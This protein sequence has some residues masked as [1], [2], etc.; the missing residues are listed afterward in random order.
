MRATLRA[1]CVHPMLCLMALL[2]VPAQA[3]DQPPVAA[4]A[5]DV[6]AV[7]DQ[8]R[9]ASEVF[10]ASFLTAVPE[11]QLRAL[12]ADMKGQFGQLLRVESVR[13]GTVPGSAEVAFR[14]ERAIGRGVMQVEPV[15]PF[16]VTGLRINSFD[17]LDDSAARIAAD[18]AALPGQTG[19]LLQRLG[20]AQPLFAHQADQPFAIGSAMKLYVLS[21]LAQE[22]Q[23]GRRSWADVVPLGPPSLSSGQMHDWPARS[24]VT[25]H[26]LATMMISISDNTATDAL[27]TLLGH[28]AVEA[29]MRASGHARPELNT[30]FL[31]T[32]QSF[33]LKGGDT[34]TLYTYAHAGEMDRKDILA[35]LAGAELD[36]ERV[37]A[38]FAAGPRAID[39]EWFASGQDIARIFQRIR[40]LPDRTAM[41]VLAIN[42]SL[43]DAARNWVY[44]GYKGGSEPGVLNLSW[45]LQDK[46]GDWYVLAM[47]WNNPQAAVDQQQ[48]ALIAQRVLALAHRP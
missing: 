8:Q 2:A 10:T 17:V 48:F 44:A 13:P 38:A 3:Q 46:A 12:A 16:R 40:A 6:V 26:T 39:V 23:A 32:R 33:L 45:L 18:L 25:L 27:I 15:P 1:F 22:V 37:M 11:A 4:R 9:P 21:A 29:E 34:G 14:F 7:L 36:R 5:D 30:P 42:P 19:V 43:G 35:D 20:T 31:T 41:D 28:E 24:P 47:S